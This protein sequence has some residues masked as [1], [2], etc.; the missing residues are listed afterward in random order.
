MAAYFSARW[1]PSTAHATELR[2]STWEGILRDLPQ[3]S[4]QK[5]E[6]WHS[7]GDPAGYHNHKMQR[8]AVGHFKGTTETP[9]WTHTKSTGSQAL[10][11]PA[12]KAYKSML[13]IH[14]AGLRVTN[15]SCSTGIS[16]RKPSQSSYEKHIP[17]LGVVQYLYS[18]DSSADT[19]DSLHAQTPFSIS[20]KP[21]KLHLGKKHQ[22]AF[23]C[24]HSLP[25][26]IWD[27]INHNAEILRLLHLPR[28]HRSSQKPEKSH[29]QQ[30]F[31]TQI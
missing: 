12:R 7:I 18:L 9:S 5:L 25:Q 20:H 30:R 24:K 1:T 10:F 22:K 6:K 31:T 23:F 21:G 17:T 28:P 16:I 4:K 15:I 13:L 8:F 11:A 19:N 27:N 3:P 29:W 2:T 14:F 26:H